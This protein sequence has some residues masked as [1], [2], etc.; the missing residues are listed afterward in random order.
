V[1]AGE[2][3][4]HGG[5]RGNQPDRHDRG[6]GEV[7]GAEEEH[8]IPPIQAATLGIQAGRAGLGTAAAAALLMRSPYLRR[9]QEIGRLR[10]RKAATRARLAQVVEQ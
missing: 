7:G 6:H 3:S 5:G 10:A 2:W 8:A 4:G 1:A 9:D